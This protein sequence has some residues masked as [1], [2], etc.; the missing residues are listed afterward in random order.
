RSGDRAQIDEYINCIE[1]DIPLIL[2]II[3]EAAETDL[4]SAGAGADNIR[5]GECLGAIGSVIVAEFVFREFSRT[6][7]LIEDDEEAKAESARIFEN[8]PPDT[9]A[10]LIAEISRRMDWSNTTPKFW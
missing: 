4:Q 6:E 5:N 3:L 2:F 8:N 1:A 9:M 7:K 10:R